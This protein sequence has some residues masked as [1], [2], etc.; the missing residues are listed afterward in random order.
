MRIFICVPAYMRICV[1]LYMYLSFFRSL[2]LSL[3]LSR[4]RVDSHLR[5]EAVFENFRRVY[6]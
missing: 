4:E 1:R 5:R 6:G 2:C 3:T